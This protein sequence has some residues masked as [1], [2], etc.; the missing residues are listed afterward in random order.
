MGKGWICGNTRPVYSKIKSAFC[1]AS[2]LKY[3]L[4]KSLSF[5]VYKIFVQ[6]ITIL[7]GEL[8]YI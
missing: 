4:G 5:G 3:L 2:S 8:V 7:T 6:N 1:V